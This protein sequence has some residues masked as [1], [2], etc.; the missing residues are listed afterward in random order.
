MGCAALFF[1]P[2]EKRGKIND[3]P[4]LHRP[5]AFFLSTPSPGGALPPDI[6]AQVARALAED[7]GP[8]DV[9]AALVPAA[10]IAHGTLIT[11]E[12]AV[13]CGTTWL[14]ETFRQLDPAIRVQWHA[15]DG[16]EL[17]ANAVLCEIHGPA[18]A[19][20]TG[21]R[22]AL[23]FVQ[24]LSGTATLVR[25]YVRAVAGT[26]CRILDTRKTL[27]GLR[28]AQK[29]AVRCGGG[30]NHRMGLYD[31]VLIKENHIISAGGVSQAI[32]AARSASPGVPV[33]VEVESLAEFRAALAAGPDVIMLDEF[34]HADMRIAVS[35]RNTSAS[36]AR[37]EASGGVDLTNIRAVAEAG[38]D[39]ISVGSLTKHM[40]AVDLSLRFQAL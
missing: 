13:L 30:H 17:V 15:R 27:P 26:S 25:Q 3:E 5:R 19:I 29:Y 14:D 20:L 8:G 9:T 4:T 31:M 24:T 6:A 10:A 34:T 40:R 21:E 22:S 35:E 37:I 36:Q 33:E 7:I 1:K 18:R 11:R 38:I 23:N 32:E 16:D 12:A 2:L 28:L 39:Y